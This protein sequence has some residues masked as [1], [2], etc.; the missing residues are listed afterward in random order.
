MEDIYACGYNFRVGYTYGFNDGLMG[1]SN[2]YKFPETSLNT[3]EKLDLQKRR[4]KVFTINENNSSILEDNELFVSRDA[5]SEKH[6][7]L[8]IG[9]N[10]GHNHGSEVRESLRNDIPEE[11]FEKSM[12]EFSNC[13]P[14]LFL[15][16]N[17]E[18]YLVSVTT[19]ELEREKEFRMSFIAKFIHKSDEIFPDKA[20]LENIKKTLSENK[21][22]QANLQSLIY[23]E[24]QKNVEVY[25]SILFEVMPE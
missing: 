7:Y 2:E 25:G 4:S 1:K 22:Q 23:F 15:Q 17:K 9:F 8:K 13:M 12:S 3:D 24:N 5:N 10:W 6:E 19:A 18:K 14:I 16:I 20:T 11:K 21:V